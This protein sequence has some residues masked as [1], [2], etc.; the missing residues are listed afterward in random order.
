MYNEQKKNPNSIRLFDF[1]SGHKFTFQ[2]E[3]KILEQR[4]YKIADPFDN[5]RIE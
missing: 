2:F 5:I 4:R 3:W 1:R